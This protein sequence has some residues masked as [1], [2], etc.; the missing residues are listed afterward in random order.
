MVV[1]QMVMDNCGSI[2]MF[3]SYYD[4]KML[5]WRQFFSYKVPLHENLMEDP[6]L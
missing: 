2:F 1:K 6:F 4:Y 5:I 3:Y